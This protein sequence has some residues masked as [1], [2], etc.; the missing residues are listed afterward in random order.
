M[1]QVKSTG[2]YRLYVSYPDVETERLKQ[3]N[4]YVGSEA[5]YLTN[6]DIVSKRGVRFRNEKLAI[7]RVEF[8]YRL[9]QLKEQLLNENNKSQIAA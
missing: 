8:M 7:Y 1:R 6:F 5:T 4:Y 2:E 3:T 9:L